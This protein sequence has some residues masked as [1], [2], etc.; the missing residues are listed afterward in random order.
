MGVVSVPRENCVGFL[1]LVPLIN[2]NGINPKLD[3][4]NYPTNFY[5]V[6]VGKKPNSGIHNYYCRNPS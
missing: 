1:T 6:L 5:L 3:N 2:E 4:K